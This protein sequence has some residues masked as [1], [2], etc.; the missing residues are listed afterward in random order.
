MFSSFDPTPLTLTTPPELRPYGWTTTD[1]WC[2]PLITGLYALLTH[3]QPFWANL[4]VLIVGIFWGHFNERG[5]KLTTEAVDPEVARAICT[6]VLIG[7]FATRAVKNFAGPLFP[8][9]LTVIPETPVKASSFK[10]HLK[11]KWCS[12]CTEMLNIYYVLQIN[13]GRQRS[14][15]SH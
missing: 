14:N 6:L 11:S 3:A 13:L 12:R 5:S 8:S 4:H 1:L 10:P 15:D 7:M 2:A 9:I